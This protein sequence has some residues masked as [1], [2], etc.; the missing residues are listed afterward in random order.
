MNDDD[1]YQQTEE[2]LWSDGIDATDD[3]V[4]ERMEEDRRNNY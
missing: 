2:D 3:M 4:Q 1:V